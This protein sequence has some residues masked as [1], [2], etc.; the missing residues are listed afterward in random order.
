MAE[1]QRGAGFR[2]ALIFLAMAGVIVPVF[3]RLKVSP[4][5]GFLPGGLFLG[6][7]GLAHF[8]DHVPW[9]GYVTITDIAS[10]QPQDGDETGRQ[11][12]FK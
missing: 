8:A 3:H 4:V 10:V 7:H 6:P 12:I 1:V 2:D 5:I 9:L 11:S